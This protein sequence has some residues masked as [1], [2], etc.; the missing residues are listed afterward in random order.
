MKAP[1]PK[2]DSLNFRDEPVDSAQERLREV[3]I[4]MTDSSMGTTEE[5]PE[6]RALRLKNA[7]DFVAAARASSNARIAERE[8]RLALDRGGMDYAHRA[9]FFGTSEQR[10]VIEARKAED[11]AIA[12]ASDSAAALAHLIESSRGSTKFGSVDPA[13]ISSGT[14][15]MVTFIPVPAFEGSKD[16]MVFK[17]GNEGLGYYAV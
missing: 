7:Q 3:E 10:A 8:E 1:K 13:S 12:V 16:G 2:Y 4:V 6:F 14:A 17:L 15:T 11:A 9:E 5:D